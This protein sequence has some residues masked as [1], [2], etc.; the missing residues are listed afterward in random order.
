[1]YIHTL[2]KPQMYIVGFRFGFKRNPLKKKKM[3]VRL[4]SHNVKLRICFEK[5]QIYETLLKSSKVLLKGRVKV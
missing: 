1:M 3:Y 2:G 5:M 4:L